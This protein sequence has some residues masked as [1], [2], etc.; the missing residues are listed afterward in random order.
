MR[1]FERAF[2]LREALVST[3]IVAVLAG[4][5]Y[6]AFAQSRLDAK[7]QLTIAQ[8]HTVGYGVYMYAA[9][10]DDWT[11]AGVDPNDGWSSAPRR[12][13]PL[14]EDM[15]IFWDPANAVPGLAGVEH[16]TDWTWARHTSI[17]ANI[18][19]FLGSW[20][21]PAGRPIM[22]Q[23]NLAKRMAFTVSRHADSAY[24]KADIVNFLAACPVPQTPCPDCSWSSEVNAVYSAAMLHGT[25]FPVLYGDLHAA[26]ERTQRVMVLS[27][28]WEDADACS[29]A[30]ASEDPGSAFYSTLREF[31]GSPVS[32]TE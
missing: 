3:A 20:D 12:I 4:V 28:N 21:H 11:P 7:N 17:G 24:G 8:L 22:A 15:D 23:E 1:K 16:G 13:I 27:S 29:A 25:S 9:T 6:P 5:L 18:Y 31:W 26:M 30:M 10:N 32:Q 14:A 2:T 19:G